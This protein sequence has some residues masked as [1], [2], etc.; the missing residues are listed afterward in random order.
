MPP[1]I[2]K[3]PAVSALLAY[4]HRRE[5]LL[6]ALLQS[7]VPIHPRGRL[8]HPSPTQTFHKKTLLSESN[9]QD[10]MDSLLRFRHGYKGSPNLGR[11]DSGQ[12]SLL[13]NKREKELEYRCEICDKVFGHLSNLNVHLR[14]HFGNTPF[15]YTRCPETYTP[16]AN[17]QKNDLLLTGKMKK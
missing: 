13:P 6:K 5:S 8:T 15:K 7:P 14:T 17:L 9:C 3:S 12:K 11:P 1:L 16:L 2:P 10:F 4:K